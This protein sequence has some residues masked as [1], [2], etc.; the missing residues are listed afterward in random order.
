[1]SMDRHFSA[2]SHEQAYDRVFHT[3]PAPDTAPS[4]V[5]RGDMDRGMAPGNITARPSV[6]LPRQLTE[7]A[8]DG[9]GF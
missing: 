3:T 4:A 5:F 6:K 2:S 7:H 8:G 1:M 9:V